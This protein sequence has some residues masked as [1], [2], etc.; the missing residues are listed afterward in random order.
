MTPEED[1]VVATR[2]LTWDDLGYHLVAE[3]YQYRLELV[4]YPIYECYDAN[5]SPSRTS[6]GGPWLIEKEFSGKPVADKDKADVI[7]SGAVKWDGCS[8]WT[9]GSPE[10]MLH[11]CT[12]DELAGIG[13]LLVRLYDLAAEMVP[14]WGV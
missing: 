2:E 1:V 11:F 7:L 9:F 6:A 3:A 13:T 12:R 5:G 14:H 8:N 10:I 4:V